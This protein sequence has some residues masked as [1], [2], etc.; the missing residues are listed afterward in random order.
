MTTKKPTRPVNWKKRQ[1]EE[2]K[3]TILL[4]FQLLVAV[5]ML[6]FFAL[7]WIANERMDDIDQRI[8]SMQAIVAEW[9][10]ADD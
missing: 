6:L 10:R 5:A 1:E 4:V 8:D 9:E 7:T 3:E 2:K